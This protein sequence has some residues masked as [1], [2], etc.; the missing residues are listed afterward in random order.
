M[1][2]Q[3]AKFIILNVSTHKLRETDIPIVSN[4]RAQQPSV[5]A[6]FGSGTMAGQ[7]RVYHQGAAITSHRKQ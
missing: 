2:Y 1:G 3:I 5:V 7:G 4:E 6:E